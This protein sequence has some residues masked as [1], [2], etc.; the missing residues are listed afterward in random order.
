MIVKLFLSFPISTS[1]IRCLPLHII[2]EIIKCFSNEYTIKIIF[3]NSYY[4][5]Y[6][7]ENIKNNNFI[8]VEPNNIESLTLEISK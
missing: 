1:L 2:E 4:S 7:L 3:D 5:K 8:A 6:L